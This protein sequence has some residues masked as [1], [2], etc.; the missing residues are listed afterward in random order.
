MC[1]R[2]WVASCHAK[3]LNHHFGALHLR[4]IWSSTKF[5]LLR[6]DSSWW[7]P[8]LYN[9]AMYTGQT[10]HAWPCEWLAAAVSRYRYSTAILVV[11][12]IIAINLGLHCT[13]LKYTIAVHPRGSY[14]VA[15]APPLF[16]LNLSW[17]IRH[18][19][20]LKK[21]K[22][23]WLTITSYRTCWRLWLWGSSPAGLPVAASSDVSRTAAPGHDAW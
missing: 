8:W 6:L 1:G 10:C 9:M 3:K 13:V 20:P 19:P 17:P 11:A 18:G 12:T 22:K 21:R 5:S 2:S 7:W 23:F 14:C 4:I 15:F 16:R